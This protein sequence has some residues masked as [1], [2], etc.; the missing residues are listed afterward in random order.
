MYHPTDRITHTTA[1][2]Y[3]S[4]GA[5]AGTRNSPMGPPWRI[6]PTTHRT[7]SERYYHGAKSRWTRSKRILQTY[8]RSFVNS[9]NVIAI[10]AV[11]LEFIVYTASWI[12]D[13]LVDCLN[14]YHVTGQGSGDFPFFKQVAE[15]KTCIE[16]RFSQS[17]NN[18]WIY[19]SYCMWVYLREC[20]Y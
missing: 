4:C 11:R 19:V 5:L 12:F 9:V 1:F 8:I 18:T 3:T 2:V 20:A 17:L 15:I 14:I 6:D 10:T 13:R 7:M 16:L